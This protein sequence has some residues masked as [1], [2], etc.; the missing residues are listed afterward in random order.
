VA[1]PT[2]VQA[3]S[4][5]PFVGLKA[6]TE[7]QADRF[8]GR[9]RECETLI[10]NLRGSRLTLLYAESGVG[11]SS[12]LRAGLAA[13]LRGRAQRNLEAR[14]TPRLLPVLFSQ[15]S[16]DPVQGLIDAVAEAARPLVGGLPPLDPPSIAGVLEQAATAVGATV[17]VLLDQF[18]EYF[19]YQARHADTDR[20]A[21]EIAA[22]VRRRE[23]NANFLI[24]IREDSYARLGDLF[25]G[26]ID[27]VYANFLHLDHLGRAGG[28]EAIRGPVD[29]FNH[30]HDGDVE[31]EDALVEAVLDGVRLDKPQGATP[32][33]NGD[34]ARVADAIETTYL[35]LVMER[36]WE[37]EA[38]QGST[39]LRVATVEAM[40][41]PRAVI[42]GHLD[43]TMDLFSDDD[44]RAAAAAFRFLVT[45][46]G[47]KIALSVND[48]SELSEVP[49]AQ[50]DQLL[51]GLA[52]PDVHILRPVELRA[53]D[54]ASYEIY[55]DALAR[56]ILEW[57][58]RRQRRE[59]QSRRE[60]LALQ[61]Q[62]ERADKERAQE[63][64]VEA[65]RQKAEAE[66][67]EALERRRRRVAVSA[68][69]VLT[70]AC[71]LAGSLILTLRE[72]ANT[73]RF[74][75]AQA[76]NVIATRLDDT[77]RPLFGEGENALAAFEAY[78]L[79]PTFDARKRV[80]AALQNNAGMPTILYGH[81]RSVYAVAWGPGPTGLL[82]TG[83]EDNTVRLWRPDGR[84]D[85]P[86]LFDGDYAQVSGLAFTPNGHLLAAARANGAVDFWAV[87]GPP[88]VVHRL[89]RTD[90]AGKGYCTTFPCHPIA[91]TPDGHMLAAVRRGD[92]VALWKL[93]GRGLRRAHVLTTVHVGG[94]GIH[95][96][97]F[98]RDGRLLAVGSQ[99]GV[100]V[101]R[102]AHGRLQLVLRPA[103]GD[104]EA[105][106][107]A[108]SPSGELAAATD[109]GVRRWTAAGRRRRLPS[110]KTGASVYAV[111]YA[112]GGA[113]LVTG[114]DD[115]QVTVWDDQTAVAVA[116][117]VP[118]QHTNTVNSLAV[119]PDGDRIAAGDD[120][121]VAKIWPLVPKRA[122]AVDAPALNGAQDVAVLPRGILATYTSDPGSLRLWRLEGSPDAP[123]A[124]R[125]LAKLRGDG[126]FAASGSQLVGFGGPD[127]LHLAIWDV[128]GACAQAAT[129]ACRRGR[130][131]PISGN[132]EDT[133]ALDRS[134]T[135]L[136]VGSPK[137][138]VTLWDIRNL[139]AVR[140][141]TRARLAR[142]GI[143]QLAFDPGARRLL[144]GTG[145]STRLWSYA[146]VGRTHRLTPVGPPLHGQ[147]LSIYT[148]AFSPHGRVLAVGGDDQT[149]TLLSLAHPTRPRELATLQQQNSIYTLAF[150]PDGRT[151]ASGDG[152]GE[153]C[154]Y[155]MTSLRT[156]GSK[157]CLLSPGAF[158]DG[159]IVSTV[160]DATGT[161]LIT[162][163]SLDDVTLWSS[164][165]WTQDAA[166]ATTRRLNAAVCRLASRNLTAGEWATVFTGTELA[167]HRHRT[168]PGLPLR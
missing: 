56:P 68:L 15:Y 3:V 96:L 114:G 29:W 78:R 125:L 91:L 9:D 119:S 94:K 18:E 31:V 83:S 71:V 25:R 11:K 28:E 159:Q 118:R 50:L 59:E 123:R 88:R 27:N 105:Y 70:L 4:E 139:H 149:V 115:Q 137:G 58:A 87:A 166:A 122:L 131:L 66:R 21:D 128:R 45:R 133:L 13:E 76:S 1:A 54:D 152:D 26:R 98:S 132:Y 17:L 97:A 43:H 143:D 116:V 30:A 74:E 134:A 107:V 101:W 124:P 104:V 85:G 23:L 77:T 92:I 47:T 19:L 7:D 129:V 20:F 106:S 145:S 140:R 110:L 156:T 14:R 167:G 109:T 130:R 24:S 148:A 102:L 51:R 142:G 151:L 36:V 154:L 158:G 67:R 53:A 46:S 52:E 63:L 12:L 79:S 112:R 39:R 93:P 126:P 162:D 35:Q 34:S 64:E 99:D 32:R 135:T 75:R 40:G 103:G 95:T 86:Q 165:L 69:V 157:T 111:A 155:D 164:L 150:S 138:R 49:V 136:A 108:W 65:Q 90:K 121:A 120:D 160:F 146:A 48:L 84:P 38:R 117:G 73:R 80:Q 57:R 37:E 89:P 153:T 62:Q 161:T 100:S 42:A 6:Y 60:E 72:R 33:R 22:C 141:L 16:E 5:R 147:G 113:Q 55:H 82:A 61:V 44:Q 8:F 10:G 2:V 127:Y 41:G 81:Q 163:G 168:C 144:V